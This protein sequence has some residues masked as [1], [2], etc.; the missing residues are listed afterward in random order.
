MA[1]PARQARAAFK[2]FLLEAPRVRRDDR[3]HEAGALSGGQNGRI[4]R[5]GQAQEQVL[6]QRAHEE[7]RLL[8][9]PTDARALRGRVDLLQGQAVGA[10]LAGLQRGYWLTLTVV[11]TLQL[12]FQGSL[13]RA[14]QSILIAEEAG[15]LILIFRSMARTAWHEIE[16]ALQALTARA[17]AI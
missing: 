7:H 2:D 16:T 6:A 5:V 8:A 10:H 12:E 1:L 9:D 13:V 3:L 14:L 15:F 11:T 17:A 4:A